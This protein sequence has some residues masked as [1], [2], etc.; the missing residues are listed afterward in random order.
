MSNYEKADKS[1]LRW[2]FLCACCEE[3]ESL[4]KTFE[5]LAIAIGQ[6]WHINV[7]CDVELMFCPLTSCRPFSEPLL[8]SAEY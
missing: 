5:V 7:A 2:V 3:N 1:A 8:P 4:G 6:L